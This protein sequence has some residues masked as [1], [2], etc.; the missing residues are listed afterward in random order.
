MASSRHWR[1]LLAL[2]TGLLALSTSVARAQDYPAKTVRIIVPLAA[3]GLADIL[4]RT[5]AQQMAATS[6][7]NVVVENRPGG[8]GAIGGEAAARSP[9]DGYTLF[10]GGQGSNATLPH[11]AKLNFDPAK[12]FVPVIHLATFPNLLVVHPDVPV[13]TVK[14]L[15]AYAKANPKKLSFASQGN[16]SSGHMVAEQFKMIAGIDMVHVPYRGAAP[17]VQDLVAG[18]VQVMFDSVTLQ[19][20]QLT[21]GKSRALAV[22]S[23]QRVDVLPDVETMIEAGFKEMAGGTWFGL[24]A[25]SGTPPQAIAWAN[26]EARKA[27]ASPDARQKFLAQGASLPLGTAAEFGAHV[28][29]ERDKWGEVIRRA[30]IKME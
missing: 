17:A 9:A 29:A 8:A 10:L 23:A 15:V 2:L 19:M 13:K 22:M 3:G 28:A 21:A 11:L 12:D 24:F 16:G 26:A 20:P 4:A 25:P 5:V 6:G 7:Q 18:H 30:G 1:L 14:E 27:F